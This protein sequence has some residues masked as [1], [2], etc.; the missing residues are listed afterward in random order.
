MLI[1][2]FLTAW[3]VIPASAQKYAAEFLTIGVGARALGM[4]G[5]FVAISDDAT[6]VYWNPAGLVQLQKKEIVLMHASRYSGLVQTNFINFAYP[7]K[8]GSTFAIS[9]F[10]MGIEDI[11]KSTKLDQFDRPIIEGY[12]QDTEHA[13][14]LSFARKGSENFYLGGNLKTIYQQVGD[15]FSLGFGFDI[16]AIYKFSDVIKL[17]LN[18]QDFSGTHVYWDTGHKDIRYPLLTWGF[19]VTKDISFLSGTAILA[20]NQ[21]IRFEGRNSENT[22]AIGDIAGSDFSY[23]AEYSFFKTM[24]FRIGMERENLTAGAGV[25]FRFFQLDYAFVSHDLENTHRISGRIL[26]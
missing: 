12:L 11:P 7:D 5:A 25:H 18:L 3:W 8:G 20:A 24:A 15:N 17:G 13:V 6:A 21:N 26:F 10:R 2:L 1:I 4:G 19:S 16:G 14:F 23:G 9:Y 22:F